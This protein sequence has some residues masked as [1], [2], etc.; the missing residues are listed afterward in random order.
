M[1]R[2]LRSLFTA[3]PPTPAVPGPPPRGFVPPSSFVAHEDCCQQHELLPRA[4]AAFLAEEVA[5]EQAH[6]EREYSPTG[7]NSIYQR[8]P[9]PFSLAGQRIPADELLMTLGQL[10][11]RRY[12]RVFLRSA[13][14]P[15]QFFIPAAQAFGSDDSALVVEV[16]DGWVQA[17]WVAERSAWNAPR[18]LILQEPLLLLGQRYELVLMD[19]QAPQLINLADAAALTR[20]VAP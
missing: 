14:G 11:L 9:L 19:W 4:N 3:P 16:Q 10:P 2:W 18:R 15:E 13:S 12:Q 6:F 20:Y 7:F 8:Q 5:R 1:F 17:L